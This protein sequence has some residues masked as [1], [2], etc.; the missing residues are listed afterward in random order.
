MK[1]SVMTV[2]AM[3]ELYK[4]NALAEKTWDMLYEMCMHNLI[5]TDDWNEFYH[6]CSGWYID[7]ERNGIADSNKNDELIYEF[8][9]LE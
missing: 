8:D 3:K 5:T 2:N 7:K 1:K 9:V 4:W 6:S